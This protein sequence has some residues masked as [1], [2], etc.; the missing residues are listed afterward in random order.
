MTTNVSEFLI[1]L[2]IGE[3]NGCCVKPAVQSLQPG[4]KQKQLT[5]IV[6]RPDSP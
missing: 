5:D 2:S 1:V 4:G 6:K 3:S